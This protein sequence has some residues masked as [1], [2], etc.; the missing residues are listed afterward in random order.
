MP[1]CTC[2]GTGPPP[3]PGTCQI[4]VGGAG[5][6]TSF[7]NIPPTGGLV[8]CQFSITGPNGFSQSGTTPLFGPPPRF[9]PLGPA[10][11]NIGTGTPYG[12]GTYT[13]TV[14]DLSPCNYGTFTQAF[15]VTCPGPAPTGVIDLFIQMTPIHDPHTSPPTWTCSC[16]SGIP[17]TGINCA[18]ANIATP[19]TLLIGGMALPLVP[20]P[21]IPGQW[22]AEGTFPPVPP[23]CQP[24]NTFHCP[25]C[26][27]GIPVCCCQLNTAPCPSP[28][29]ITI[30]FIYSEGSG[31]C[32]LQ[33]SVIAPVC[34]LIPGVGF[35]ANSCACT[36]VAFANDLG[37]WTSAS[38][39]TI[40]TCIP[41][42]VVGRP[43]S[44]SCFLVG[45]PP[46]FSCAD[47]ALN[48]IAGACSIPG[49]QRMLPGWSVI[50]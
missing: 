16:C 30:L 32:G 21:G 14:T 45:G 47:G 35:I 44:W 27:P 34:E 43:E 22:T 29:A 31:T 6:I 4:C 36:G 11:F 28:T 39:P 48:A 24:P 1:H 8:E 26:P 50:G 38:D 13:L 9:P 2:C 10:C 5:C 12:S 23:C 20:T 41:Y 40:S 37:P 46:F 18:Q 49:G 15:N 3:P 33:A 42:N 25:E 19:K 17:G 7:P